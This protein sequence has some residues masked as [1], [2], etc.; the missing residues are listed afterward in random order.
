MKKLFG[1][2]GVRGVANQ[3]LTPEMVFQIGQAAGRRMAGQGLGKVLIARDT[4]RSGP[5]L[6]AALAS[7]F[8]SSGQ[9]VDAIGVF[10]T[11]GVSWI[12]RQGGFGLGAVVSASHNPAPDNGVK[13]LGPDGRKASAEME[14]WVTEHM[15]AEPATRPTG[16]E[17]GY[18]AQPK[19]LGAAYEDWLVSLVPEGL[20]GLTVAVDAGNGAAYEIAPRV[21]ERLGACVT[22]TGCAPDG[23]NINAE[24]G[25]TKPETILGLTKSEGC[26]VGVAFDGDADR[27][28]FCDD[29]GRLI[30]GDRTMAIW[31]HHWRKHGRLEPPLVVGTV[32]TN[33]GFEQAMKRDGIEVHRTDVGD[34]YVSARLGETSGRIGGEQSGHII[35]PEHLPTG[36]GLVTCLELLRV[37][38]REGKRA[39]EFF[40]DYEPWPQLLINVGVGQKEGWEQ[41]PRVVQALEDARGALDG[42]GRINVRASGTQPMIRVMVEADAG[43]V[44]DAVAESVVA[45][46]V[47]SLDGEVVGRVDL[48]YAL[49]D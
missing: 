33:G 3:F 14:A 26:A 7:G 48:T 20:E 11:G 31:C 36:D 47:E 38:Q 2:D 10:P 1:T 15:G 13:L 22:A 37:L 6:G 27:A 21:L 9:D 23:V 30:N 18:L 35:F 42:R 8:C 12:L 32:M 43:S 41:S 44:R 16:P 19:Q 45:A 34:K 46:L 4:R 28:V 17:I 24:G 29:Q 40:D 25:A 49:G 39:A 5:M